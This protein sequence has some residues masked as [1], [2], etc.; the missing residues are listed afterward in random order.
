M[1]T[2]NFGVTRHDRVVF[3]DYDEITL[4]SKPV[5]KKIP[6]SKTY[7]EEMASEPWYYVGPNDVFPEEFQYFM[8]PS[9]HMKETFNA[10]YQKLLDAEYWESI[11]ENIKKYG[12]MDYYPYGSEKRMCEIYGENN[13]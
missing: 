3:Y 1:L 13:E 7:E 9:K 12:V 5:F 8:L 4:M 10:H 11:Q 2:K 6:E